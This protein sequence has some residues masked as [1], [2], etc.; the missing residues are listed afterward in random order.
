LIFQRFSLFNAQFYVLCPY[1]LKQWEVLCL[2]DYLI[3]Q[4][5]GSTLCL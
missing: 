4:S 5:C 3:H 1:K 2:S